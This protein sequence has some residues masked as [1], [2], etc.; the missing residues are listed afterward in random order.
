MPAF[1]T[2]LLNF[3]HFTVDSAKTY[4]NDFH[5]KPHTHHSYISSK[6]TG[7]PFYVTPCY[8]PTG[9]EAL[10][11]KGIKGKDVKLG[12]IDSGITLN[13]KAFERNYNY[14]YAFVGTD[15][16][17]ANHSSE[18]NRRGVCLAGI[19][20][21]KNNY[22]TGVA[23]EATL[24]I[25]RVFGCTGSTSTS[26]VLKAIAAAIKN[27]IKII[28]LPEIA[29]VD[30]YNTARQGVIM[31]VAVSVNN[32]I[33]Q[34]YFSYQG[35]PVLSV[36]GFKQEYRLSHWFEEK[37]TGHCIEF[38]SSCLNMSYNFNKEADIIPKNINGN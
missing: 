7:K 17:Q 25:Y 11:A 36:G 30:E 19:A 1:F 8:V 12:I 38:M 13:A 2:V 26:L 4:E 22:F 6:S 9:V 18:C 21:A 29:I 32:F 15:N 23:P 37:T 24:G 27:Q 10:Y 34:Q 3:K 16:N 33:K 20:V 14:F 28:V 35:L 31:I 5:T